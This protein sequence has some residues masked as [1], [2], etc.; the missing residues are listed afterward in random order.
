MATSAKFKKTC[1][2][3]M[4]GSSVIKQETQGMTFRMFRENNIEI[5]HII[6]KSR[7]KEM[8]NV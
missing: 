2:A 3:K 6:E 8:M 4:G 1:S 5:K 7:N